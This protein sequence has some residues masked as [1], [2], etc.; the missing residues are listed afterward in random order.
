M[1]FCKA[2]TFRLVVTKLDGKTAL[3]GINFVF[4]HGFSASLAEASFGF[5]ASNVSHGHCISFPMTCVSDAANACKSVSLEISFVLVQGFCW[6]SSFLGF[7]W[8]CSF[9]RLLW[10]IYQLLHKLCPQHFLFMLFISHFFFMKILHILLPC[11]GAI[12]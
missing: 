7:F 10:S 6:F 12:P 2:Y 1:V 11:Q 5:T 8:F 4:E 3:L 9:Q